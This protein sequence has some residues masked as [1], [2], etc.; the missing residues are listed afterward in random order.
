MQSVSLENQMSEETAVR[1]KGLLLG[2]AALG[3]GVIPC[4][5]SGLPG[6]QPRSALG[7]TLN[8]TLGSE[9]RPSSFCAKPLL[10]PGSRRAGVILLFYS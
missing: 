9:H 4:T 5:D 6:P 10:S 7:P 8:A 3:R 2:L 1:G